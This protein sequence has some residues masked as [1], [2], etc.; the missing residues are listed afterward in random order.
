MRERSALLRTRRPPY[1]V[2][3]RIA[4]EM[5]RRRRRQSVTQFNSSYGFRG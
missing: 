5:Y 3:E 1:E 2:Y 4:L